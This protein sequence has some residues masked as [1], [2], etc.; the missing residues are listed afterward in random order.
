MK[1]LALALLL[2]STAARA[3]EPPKFVPFTVT[4]DDVKALNAQLE[5]LPIKMLPATR[6]IGFWLNGLEQKAKAAEDAKEPPRP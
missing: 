6:V 3:A 5:E 4:E 1:R 2:I